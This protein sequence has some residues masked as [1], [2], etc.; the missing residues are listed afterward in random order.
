MSAEALPSAADRERPF[1]RGRLL[2]G[3]SLICLLAAQPWVVFVA[4]MFVVY[5]VHWAR[6][7][8]GSSVPAMLTGLVYVA[9]RMAGLLLPVWLWD[10]NA[11]SPLRHPALLL[12]RS[13]A[14]AMFI[15]VAI[16]NLDNLVRQRES[17]S[18]AS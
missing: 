18:P 13:C 9:S 8:R 12:L 4:P 7:T 11:L 1:S 6:R 2:V 5:G 16:S 3:L 14:E 10:A 15:A 17:A